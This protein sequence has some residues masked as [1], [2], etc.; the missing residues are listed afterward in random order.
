MICPTQKRV[1]VFLAAI[2]TY[3][4]II[5]LTMEAGRYDYI[6]LHYLPEYNSSEL[7]GFQT[8]ADRVTIIGV[9]RILHL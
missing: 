4:V 8:F 2:Q 1:I 7:P 5:N 6:P 9:R 3:L